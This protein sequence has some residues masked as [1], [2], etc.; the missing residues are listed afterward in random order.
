MPKV[1]DPFRFVLIAVVGWMNQRQLQMIE[2]LREE[3]RV[4]REQLG[5]RRLRLTD[6][7]RRRLAAKARGL[8][9]KVLAEVATIVTPETLLRWHRQ[10]IAQKY[11]GSGRRGPGRPRTAAEIEQVVVQMAEQ[12]R[13]WGY[14]RIQGAL[15]NLGHKLARSTIA[16]ILQR[17]GIEPAPE[18]SHKTTWKEF[19]TRHWELIAAAD[20]FTI[21][22]WT[23]KGLQRFLVLF[24]IDLSTRRVQVAGISAVANGLW[25]NQIARNLTDSVDGLLTGKRY[26]IHDR[27]P[28]FTHEFLHML[29]GAG[30][31]SVKL[32]PRSPNLNAHAER[33]VRS[34]KE[35]CLE[36]LILFGE[37]S[38]R[39]AV[40]NFIAHYHNERNHQGLSNRLIQPERD[41][42]ENTGAIQRRQRLGGMLNYYY[43]TAA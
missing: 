36:R 17:H 6:D 30:V 31:E 43:R 28:L 16:D 41:H 13:D 3:N 8:G 40:Q 12:N 34:I 32:P 33:F 14:R 9:R 37:S 29:K 5:E 20:F 18:R 7:Q 2:Y 1:V 26:L 19:L 42:L 23:A 39:T 10:L 4:L 38:L 27:D 15:S 24:L 22:V 11:D 21:E 25:M 35:S